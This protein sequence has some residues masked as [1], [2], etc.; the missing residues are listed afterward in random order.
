MKTFAA[1]E[2][3]ALSLTIAVKVSPKLFPVRKTSHSKYATRNP[4]LFRSVYGEFL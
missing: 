4:R 2:A 1:F 3:L